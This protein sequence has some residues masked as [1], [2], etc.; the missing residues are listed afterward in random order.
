MTTNVDYICV[1]RKS[2][3][4][5]EYDK[6][7]IPRSHQDMMK[8][9]ETMIL[10]DRSTVCDMGALF[11]SSFPIKNDF[12]YC[13]PNNY[14]DVS[15]SSSS[16]VY[17]ESIKEERY[18][19][20]LKA[21]KEEYR[22]T[23]IKEGD[24]APDEIE[25]I[26]STKVRDW[27]RDWKKGCFKRRQEY[28]Y[29]FDYYSLLRQ[30]EKDKSVKMYS[31]EVIGEYSPK[32]TMSFKISEDITFTLHTNFRFGNSSCFFLKMTYKGVQ[33]LFYS[34]YVKYYFASALDIV[35]YTKRFNPLRENWEDALK[36]VAD[37]SNKAQHNPRRFEE[38]FIDG[39]ITELVHG[40]REIKGGALS[41]KSH[42]ERMTQFAQQSLYIGLRTIS[43]LEVSAYRLHPE[44][45]ELVYKTEK[46]T[47][48]LDLLES[49]RV[50]TTVSSKVD[51]A[52]AEIQEMN[53]SIAP[54]ILSAIDK[55]ELELSSLNLKIESLTED[56]I[57]LSALLEPYEAKRSSFLENVDRTKH[58][59][60]ITEFENENPEYVELSKKKGKAMNE[61]WTLTQER[62]Y[63]L[64]F[65]NSL[66]QCLDRIKTSGLL[67]A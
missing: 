49:M 51:S 47:G 21:K 67:V 56:E 23:L 62:D 40:L 36:I 57:R 50:F 60:P 38:E 61:K 18:L 15:Y 12:N 11:D 5:F 54:Q 17:P 42:I 34:D 29:A 13:Y 24:K 7:S 33:L 6:I 3:N 41:V 10:D 26:V 55:I 59:D 2:E 14:W 39:Q 45:M 46:I 31:T 4:G 8:K 63:R 20:E 28:I 27:A 30:L 16:G 48:A 64:S 37:Y 9:L 66:Q 44:D 52:I 32:S 19:N 25:G 43:G 22:N 53:R 65:K 1:V 58:P 35:R